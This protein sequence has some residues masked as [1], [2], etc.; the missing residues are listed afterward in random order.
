[1]DMPV[2]RESVALLPAG[3]GVEIVDGSILVLPSAACMG[4]DMPEAAAAA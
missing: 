1:M 3:M 2:A 4:Q